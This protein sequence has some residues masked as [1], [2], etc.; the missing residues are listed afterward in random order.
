MRHQTPYNTLLCGS[1]I[2]FEAVW[3]RKWPM[4]HRLQKNRKRCAI[5]GHFAKP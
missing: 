4:S 2:G 3:S 5:E 1:F